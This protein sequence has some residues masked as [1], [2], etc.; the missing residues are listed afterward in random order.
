MA[1]LGKTGLIV[2]QI[3]LSLLAGWAV[4]RTGRLLD[5]SSRLSAIAAAIYLFLP[6]T[7]V[8]PHQL[9]SEAIHSPLLAVSIWLTAEYLARQAE[10]GRLKLLATAG[11]LVGLITLVR[12]ITLLWPLV[13]ALI[14]ARASRLR[15]GGLYLALAC[16]PILLWMSFISGQSGRFNMGDSSHDMGHNLYQ[17]VTRIG[18]TLP[19]NQ[20]AAIRLRF[21]TQGEEGSI[22]PVEYL[23]FGMAYPLPFIKQSLRDVLI[24]TGKSGVERLTIDYLDI[25]KRAREKLQNDKSGWRGIMERQGTVATIRYLWK[26]EGDV[27]LISLLGSLLFVALMA[28][29]IGGGWA[30]LRNQPRSGTGG[31][32]AIAWLL[33]GLPIYIL[34]FSQVVNAAQSRHRSPAEAPLALLAAYGGARLIMCSREK[35]KNRNPS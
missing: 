11:L 31:Q 26:T 4:F 25:N 20:Q 17:R 33:I 24:L 10:P 30:L 14:V 7:L 8:F 12:P 23:R 1:W 6:Q 28:L 19:A 5:W 29:A 18:E 27:L 35:R 34:V 21:L 2:V 13:T 22:D 3:A 32:R 9:I 15:T 16:L